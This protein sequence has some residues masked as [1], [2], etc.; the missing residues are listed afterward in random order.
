MEI[1]E[2]AKT[3]TSNATGSLDLKAL[4]L[5]LAQKEVSKWSKPKVC[6]NQENG[7]A[8]LARTPRIRNSTSASEVQTHISNQKSVKRSVYR[9]VLKPTSCCE[10]KDSVT[11]KVCGGRYFLEVD[12]IKPRWAFNHQSDRSEMNDPSNLRILCSEH[13]RFRYSNNQ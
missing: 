5:Y 8:H 6:A 2:Q 10:Y 12:H 11:G 7:S 3:L 13:N 4:V 1:I 9:A